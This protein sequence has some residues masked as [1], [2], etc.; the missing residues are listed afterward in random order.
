MKY[1]I[2]SPKNFAHG[3]LDLEE[4]PG[5]CCMLSGENRI[6]I[7]SECL[8]ACLCLESGW[9]HSCCLLSMACKH[10]SCRMSSCFFEFQH[11]IAVSARLTW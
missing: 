9:C 3:Q 5:M 1:R 7:S 8:K 4:P 6:V 11:A 10:I 2:A